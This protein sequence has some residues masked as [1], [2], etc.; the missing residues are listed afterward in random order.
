[1]ARDRLPHSRGLRRLADKLGFRI[2]F[3]L[4]LALLPLALLSAV[5]TVSL[6]DQAQ[7]RAEAAILGDTVRV[8]APVLQHILRAQGSA[9]TLASA[10]AQL[11][12]DPEQCRNILEQ[13]ALNNPLYSLVAFIP[14]SGKMDCS[15]S[16]QNYD[17]SN[18]AGFKDAI[19]D[20]N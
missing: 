1:M 15:G 12:T 17:F 7:S 13:F 20:P 18:S 4:A 6:S 3:L 16:G 9:A 19:A 10:V 5:Q 14:P 8:A 11:G 2:T